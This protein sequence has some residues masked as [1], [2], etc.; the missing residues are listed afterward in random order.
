[1]CII[2]AITLFTNG[3]IDVSPQSIYYVNNITK[4]DEGIIPQSMSSDST[5]WN[6]VYQQA[7]LIFNI[8][9]TAFTL[10]APTVL[11]VI[12]N[13]LIIHGLAQYNKTFNSSANNRHR[14][15]GSH[16]VNIEVKLRIVFNIINIS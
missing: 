1:V 11:I 10:V 13:A 15:R 12:M 6:S 4:D 3:V 2:Q 14:S 7:I 9:E 8:F 16:Q 5:N